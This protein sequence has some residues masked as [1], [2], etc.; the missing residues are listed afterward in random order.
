MNRLEVLRFPYRSKGFSSQMLLLIPCLGAWEEPGRNR[1]LVPCGKTEVWPP[2]PSKQFSVA[3]WLKLHCHR[4]TQ[5]RNCLRGPSMKHWPFVEKSLRILAETH[6]ISPRGPWCCDLK[7]QR[8]TVASEKASG[9]PMK[10]PMWGTLS[11]SPGGQWKCQVTGRLGPVEISR[12]LSSITHQAD[13]LWSH[14]QRH[15]FP[16]LIIPFGTGS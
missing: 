7:K 11:A 1:C 3:S 9:D 13:S 8:P 2:F 14:S 10:Y 4:D 5:P 6:G 15:I 16:G 12:M